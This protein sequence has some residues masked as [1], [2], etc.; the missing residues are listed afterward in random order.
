MFGPMKSLLEV[1]RFPKA[2]GVH[3][4]QNSHHIFHKQACIIKWW[5]THSQMQMQ[6]W[7]TMSLVFLLRFYSMWNSQSWAEEALEKKIE[8]NI[9]QWNGINLID[10][11]T[12]RH[13]FPKK[14]IGW[15]ACCLYSKPPTT[16]VCGPLGSILENGCKPLNMTPP[17]LLWSRKWPIR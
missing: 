5:H 10:C 7:L 11:I 12:C 6:K 15:W 13:A 14:G 1:S 2:Q 16:S 3:I 8:H 4:L 17:I 9:L